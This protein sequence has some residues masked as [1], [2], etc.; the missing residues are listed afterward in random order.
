M[1]GTLRETAFAATAPQT[2]NQ[3]LSP[4]GG[5]RLMQNHPA[6][7]PTVSARCM[8]LSTWFALDAACRPV[9]IKTLQLRVVFV[10]FSSGNIGLER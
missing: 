8:C 10:L 9:W 4:H 6:R 1:S 7:R 3:V 5:T 2:P